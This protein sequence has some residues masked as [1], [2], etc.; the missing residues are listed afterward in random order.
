MKE[1]L[2]GITIP[3]TQSLQ[4]L[5][6]RRYVVLL[7]GKGKNKRAITAIRAN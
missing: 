3:V 4:Q 7:E 2:V 1:Q 5:A 6:T